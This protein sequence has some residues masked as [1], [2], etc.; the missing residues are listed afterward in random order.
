MS[1]SVIEL[2]IFVST[3]LH[4]GATSFN[5]LKAWLRL[6]MP[7]ILNYLQQKTNLAS[8]NCYLFI[9][10]VWL[11]YIDLVFANYEM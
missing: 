5:R 7:A 2:L 11:S 6:R 4:L 8:F 10:S 3:M 1:I 9:L